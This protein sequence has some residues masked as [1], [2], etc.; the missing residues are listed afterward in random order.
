M[1]WNEFGPVCRM[2][3]WFGSC[4]RQS[5]GAAVSRKPA[6]TDWLPF[7]VTVHV[8][9]VPPQPAPLQPVK[10]KYCRGCAV[11]V[12]VVPGSKVAR[13]VGGQAMPVPVTVPP[14][15]VTV[16]VNRGPAPN[17]AVTCAPPAGTVSWQVAVGPQPPPVQLVNWA[18]A[19]GV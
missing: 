12:T 17:A 8:G 6:V 7:I 16:T 1:S 3:S 5:S 15:A 19:D 11:S 9:A 10:R 18:P 14:P 2:V 13:Q 4:D